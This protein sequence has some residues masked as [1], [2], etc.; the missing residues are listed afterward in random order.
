[1]KPGQS[2][3]LRFKAKKNTRL[4]T[5]TSDLINKQKKAKLTFSLWWLLL[6]NY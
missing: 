6:N 2:K 5:S 3:T 1:M 4:S